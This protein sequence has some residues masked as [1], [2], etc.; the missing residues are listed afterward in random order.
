MQ[1]LAGE[2]GPLD[3][4]VMGG[5]SQSRFTVRAGAGPDGG[6]AGVFSGQ[7]QQWQLF[8][9]R[10]TVLCSWGLSNQE[11]A[12]KASLGRCFAQEQDL[13]LGDMVCTVEPGEGPDSGRFALCYGHDSSD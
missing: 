2:W 8:L 9:V 13:C 12:L 10:C 5:V 3:D 1:G 4:V 11:P 7:C 6:P